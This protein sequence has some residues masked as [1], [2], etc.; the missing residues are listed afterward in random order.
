MISTDKEPAMENVKYI[1]CQNIDE[2][3]Q[4]ILNL[5]QNIIVN[6]IYR[7]ESSVKYSLIPSI[8]RKEVR[9][10]LYILINSRASEEVKDGLYIELFDALKI[11]Y[12][13]A[14][15]QGL[16]IPNH[17]HL[18]IQH[19]FLPILYTSDF[20]QNKKINP[21]YYE[22]IALAQH[23]N[24][25]TP[26]LDWT[27]DFYV[28]FFFAFRSAIYKIYG[29]LCSESFSNAVSDKIAIWALDRGNLQSKYK[30]IFL[31]FITP[32]YANNPNLAA[33]KGTF[34][35]HDIDIDTHS[36]KENIQNLPLDIYLKHIE[37]KFNS[38]VLYK[39]TL[40]YNEAIDGF[41]YLQKIGYTYSKIFPGYASISTEMEDG[42]ILRRINEHLDRMKSL[43]NTPSNGNSEESLRY[44]R[45]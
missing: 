34:S 6:W 14:N 13:C 1:D 44:Q 30:D 35:Y 33:Q 45:A 19:D 43:K 10:K 36:K 17:S 11:F 8:L 32:R 40:P 39:F 24:I 41:V 26:F 3:T 25:P 15:R 2:L 22:L 38:P 9:K 21:A 28:A 29:K 42:T 23:Y 18:Q 31:R 20:I 12:E 7:G 37:R 27:N 4:N 5:P 16:Y